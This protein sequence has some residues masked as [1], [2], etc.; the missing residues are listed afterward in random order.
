MV[1]VHIY[2]RKSQQRTM[3]VMKFWKHSCGE[4]YTKAN[5]EQCRDF[6]EYLLVHNWRC[7]F[8]TP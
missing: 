3:T 4:V 8:K 7:T 5:N 6:R 2:I 1:S